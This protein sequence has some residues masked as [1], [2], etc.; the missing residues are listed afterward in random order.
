[1]LLHENNIEGRNVNE[2]IR[3]N[4]MRRLMERERDVERKSVALGKLY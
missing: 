1:M 4:A 2:N 3:V